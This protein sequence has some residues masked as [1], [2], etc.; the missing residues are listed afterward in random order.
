MTSP[1]DLLDLLITGIDRVLPD[2]QEVRRTLHRRPELGGEEDAT[3]GT[4]QSLL[5]WLTWRPVAGTGMYGRLG[6]A[7]PAV[8]LRA[9]MDALPI[10]ERTGVEWASERPGVMHACGHDVHMAALWATLTAARAL[11]L[12]VGL[13]P[14]FQPRE[15]ISPS[16]A[17]DIVEAGLLG[18][19][20]VRAMIGVHLQPRVVEGVISTGAGA[21]N[22]AFDEF[23]VTVHGQPGHGAYPHTTIDPIGI[24]ASIIVGVNELASRAIDPTHATVMSIGRIEGGNAPNVIAGTAYAAGTIRTTDDRDREQLHHDLRRLVELT[25]AARGATAEL[26][27]VPGGSMLVNDAALVHAIDPLI[28]HTGV[29]RA[30]RPFRSCGSDDFSAYCEVVPS[31]MMFAGTGTVAGLT[32]RVQ[33]GL[34]H[35]RFL[36]PDDALRLCAYAFAAGYAG[37]SE[38]VGRAS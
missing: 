20:S 18:Q 38:L 3:R 34:H 24:L 10:V 29:P 5:D 15:E 19:E 7:G 17:I 23:Y 2:A 33:V 26:S 25:A 27:I 11:D 35:E 36:P 14:I 31:V 13:V 37:A 9:E 32:E 21:V 28:D 8:G 22:A 30:P 4:L 6:P 12:P 16:G 1:T